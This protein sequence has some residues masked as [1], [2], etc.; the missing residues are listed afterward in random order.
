ML[1]VLTTK[2]KVQG[3]L[4]LMDMSITLIVVMFHGCLHM[5]KLITLYT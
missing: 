3:N 5:L 4:G 2:G 1:S